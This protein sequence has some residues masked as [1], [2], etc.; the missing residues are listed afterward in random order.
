MIQLTF[1]FRSYRHQ[2]AID[3]PSAP[4]LVVPRRAASQRHEEEAGGGEHDDDVLHDEAREAHGVELP[5]TTHQHVH[6]QQHGGG[7]HQGP[8]DHR[9]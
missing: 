3:A 8:G 1:F 6:L 5:E 7:E 4:P 9:G 2:R